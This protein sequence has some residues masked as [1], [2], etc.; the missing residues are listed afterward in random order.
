MIDDFT[1]FEHQPTDWM[2][3][4]ACRNHPKQW[5]F[6]DEHAGPGAAQ[7]AKRI[8]A[9]CAVRDACLN[10][11][12]AVPYLH[13]IWG[14]LTTK[15][16]QQRPGRRTRNTQIGT[17]RLNQPIRHGTY[18]GYHAHRRRGEPA[19]VDCHNAKTDYAKAYRAATH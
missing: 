6:P 12:D 2:A 14:G 5:W 15:E 8:C 18:G 3:G 17:S 16:R 19:C 11:A 4:A 1:H 7:Q 13:G 10:Y 9:D